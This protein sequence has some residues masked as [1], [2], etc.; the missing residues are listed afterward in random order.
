MSIRIMKIAKIF[1]ALVVVLVHRF[2][3]HKLIKHLK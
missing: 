2:S 3:A 1:L